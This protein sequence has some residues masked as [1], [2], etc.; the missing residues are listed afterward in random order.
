M[1]VA[2]IPERI[3]QIWESHLARA[4]W[5]TTN[6]YR[7][8]LRGG[9]HHWTDRKASEPTRS[10][11]RARSSSCKVTARGVCRPNSYRLAFAAFG[12]RVTGM[13]GRYTLF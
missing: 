2:R 13:C 12:C 10:G 6:R 1:I 8:L 11:K 9:A 7:H 4:K 5:M 3:K